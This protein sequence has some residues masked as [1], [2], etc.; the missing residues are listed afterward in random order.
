MSK[1]KGRLETELKEL[2][3]PSKKWVFQ[4]PANSLYDYLHPSEEAGMSSSQSKDSSH[5]LSVP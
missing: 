1:S 3:R 4:L 5:L 2:N